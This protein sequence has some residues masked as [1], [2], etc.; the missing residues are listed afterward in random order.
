MFFIRKDSKQQVW[1]KKKFCGQISCFR[2]ILHERDIQFQPPSRSCFFPGSHK[3]E[4]CFRSLRGEYREPFFA[5]CRGREVGTVR[6][7][8]FL[9]GLCDVTSLF[10]VR[11]FVDQFNLFSRW[12]LFMLEVIVIV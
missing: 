2:L 3:K 8:T 1:K 9:R 10:T 12:S 6:R 7:S 11:I 4:G 5:I